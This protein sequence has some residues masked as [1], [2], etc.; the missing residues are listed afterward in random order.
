MKKK[1]VVVGG[2]SQF[3]VGLSESLIDYA[4]DRLGGTEVVLLDIQDKHLATVQNYALRLANSVGVDMKFTSLTDRKKAFE[5]ADFILTTFRPGSHQQ[6]EQ[7][8]R[9]PPKYG[10]QG[11]ETVSIGGIFMACRVVPALKEIC[12]DAQQFCPQAWII[13]YTNPTQYVADAVKHKMP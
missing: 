13:N 3:S 9:I 11:N 10:L 4:R 2:G 1:I 8:E 7:D 5:G 6:Q 12:A